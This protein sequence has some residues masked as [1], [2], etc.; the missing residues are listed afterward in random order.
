VAGLVVGAGVAG[1]VVG[2]GVAGIV[3]GAGVAGIVVG[4]GVAGIVVGAGVVE[5]IQ[6]KLPAC[7]VMFGGQ[8]K[9]VADDTAPTAVEYF[10]GAQF[11]HTADPLP[12]LYFPGKHRMH[13]S[14][15]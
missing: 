8:G 10:P 3:V 1:L 7:E 4:A 11:S 14:L 5:L 6:P 2:A 15:A 13:F 12:C 9:H